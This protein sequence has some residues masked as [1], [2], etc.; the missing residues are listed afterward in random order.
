MREEKARN[1]A[2]KKRI[3]SVEND[4]TQQQIVTAQ[5]QTDVT[6]L[7]AESM[8]LKTGAARLQSDMAQVRAY[9]VQLQGDV[10]Q[11]QTDVETAHI[12]IRQLGKDMGKILS[13]QCHT[14]SLMHLS[15]R[16]CSLRNLGKIIALHLPPL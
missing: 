8:Q 15:C 2:L 7:E 6:Q 14:F 16:S 4:V 5:I 1:D 12:G 10:V 11:L 3:C 13:E 9:S